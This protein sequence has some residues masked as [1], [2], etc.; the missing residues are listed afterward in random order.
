MPWAVSPGLL[1][2]VVCP[3]VYGLIGGIAAVVSAF[4]YN[5]AARMVG[6]VSVEIN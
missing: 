6:G 4:L 1:A 2:V 5:L 3:I